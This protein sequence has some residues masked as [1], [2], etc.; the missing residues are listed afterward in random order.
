LERYNVLLN[1]HDGSF[2]MQRGRL[3]YSLMARVRLRSCTKRRTRENGTVE[4]NREL[5]EAGWT[6]PSARDVDKGVV[7]EGGSSWRREAGEMF[8]RVEHC[9][10]DASGAG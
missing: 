9:P 8:A 5:K 10:L 3:L 4:V 7:G 1:S 6:K 2:H